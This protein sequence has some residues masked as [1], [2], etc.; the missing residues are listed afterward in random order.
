MD[1]WTDELSNT[2]AYTQWT[3]IGIKK[4]HGIALPLF[5]LRSRVS[6]GIGEYPDLL[7]LIDFCESIGFDVIQLLPLNDSGPETSPYSAM[8]ALALNP[9]YLGISSLPFLERMQDG[10]E[11]LLELQ[12]LN[13]LQRISYPVIQAKR[14]AFLRKYVKINKEL[15]AGSKEYLAFVQENPW[16][17]N[18]ALFKA[19]KIDTQWQMWEEWPLRLKETTQEVYLDLLSHYR[20]EILYHSILQYFCF[21]QFD[22]SKKAAEAKGIF[23]KGDIPILIN[24]ESADVWRYKPFYDLAYA[25]GAPPDMYALEGQK[26]G[27]PIYNWTQIEEHGF[28]P[29]KNRLKVA[30]TLYHL[31]R[32]DHV[33]GFFRIWAIP[34][35]KPAKE[36]HFIPWNKSEWIPQGRKIMEMMLISSGMLP[37]AEDLGTVPPEV[38]NCLRELGICGTKVMRWERHWEGDRSFLKKEEYPLISMTTVS[39]HDSETLQLWWRKNPEEA[40]EYAE[41]KGLVYALELSKENHQKILWESHHTNSL[42]HINLLQEYLALIPDMTWED[43]EEERINT[44]GIISEKNW[45]YRFR[46][47]LE[48]ITN[49]SKL[50]DLMKLLIMP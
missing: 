14:E 47:F 45:T 31:Y 10:H 35:D 23:L 18:F 24:R 3:K 30:D 7:P 48:E 34:L 36:G 50:A 8:S 17:E 28:L 49:N 27:F 42:F 20:E 25:A 44:P 16:L 33:V 41:A 22:A 29:W 13:N 19:I 11:M 4:H 2:L 9:L 15:L 12:A 32:L 26:W 46:P 43:P 1:V 21:K 6:C 5:S 37:I 38:R 39:T 40:K